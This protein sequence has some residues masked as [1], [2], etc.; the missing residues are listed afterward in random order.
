LVGGCED[1]PVRVEVV[2]WSPEW[3]TEFEAVAEAL[4]AALADVPSAR[5]EHVGSTAVPG[6]AAKPVLDIDVVVDGADLAAAV[7]ALEDVGYLHRGDLGVTGR[8][9]FSAPDDHPRR[10]VHVCLDGA[11]A[12]RNHLAVREVLRRRDDLRE[13]YGALK[14]LLAA[15]PGID[16]ATYV[17][18]KSAVLA[19]VLADSDLTEEERRAIFSAGP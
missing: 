18:G 16:V 5:V 7:D 11:L 8:E 3:A 9:A 12:L 1:G 14:Q 13:A 10:N 2:A 17:A 4:R 6:L 15:Q 19:E